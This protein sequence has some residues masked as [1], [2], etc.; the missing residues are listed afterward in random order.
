MNMR[1]LVFALVAFALACAQPAAAQG[2]AT[3]RGPMADILPLFAKNGC[4]ELRDTAEQLFCGDP[5]LN[6]LVVRLGKVR[7]AKLYYL[8][9]LTGK[10][11]R[12]KE[13]RDTTAS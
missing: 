11:A 13:R 6:P 5:D 12:I 2:V 4:A 1:S 7:R 8:R 9:G 10:A 3:P